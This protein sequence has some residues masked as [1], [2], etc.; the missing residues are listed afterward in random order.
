[1]LGSMSKD[2]LVII[3]VVIA[4]ISCFYLFNQN[5]KTA[6]DIALLKTAAKAPVPTMI[7]TK[8]KPK[9]RSDPVT[10]TLSEPEVSLEKDE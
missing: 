2:K 4:L 6:A 5:K 10:V 7:Q 8:P 3:A 9:P 1:M